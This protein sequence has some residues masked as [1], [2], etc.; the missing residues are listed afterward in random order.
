MAPA[1]LP[2]D[3]K[4]IDFEL[5]SHT[6]PDHYNVT[7]IQKLPGHP[8]IIMPWC[9]G[10]Q[11]KQLGFQVIEL[12]PWASYESSGLKITATPAPHMWGHCLGYVIE[13]DGKK[14]YFTGDT[15]LFKSMNRIHE[16]GIDLMLLPYGGYPMLG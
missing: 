10:K 14:I 7:D 12:R 2:P 6:H 5:I 1:V 16:M 13:I 3:L 11:L 9:R 15:K 4:K 8:T